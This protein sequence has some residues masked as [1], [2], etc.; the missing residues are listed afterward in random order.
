MIFREI[1]KLNQGPKRQKYGL[2]P[3][4]L[5]TQCVEWWPQYL[6]WWWTNDGSEEPRVVC[7]ENRIHDERRQ[8]GQMLTQTI[9]TDKERDQIRFNVCTEGWGELLTNSDCHWVLL[10]L[11]LRH[12]DTNKQCPIKSETIL[13][14]WYLYQDCLTTCHLQLQIY[15]RASMVESWSV[16]CMEQQAGRD[17]DNT[18]LDS[19]DNVGNE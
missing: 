12:W 15:I 16:W 5:W 2:A 3:I 7:I 4:D 8:A 10:T 14:P 1:Q 19:W 6:H 13:L 11:L 17:A 18:L 9:E